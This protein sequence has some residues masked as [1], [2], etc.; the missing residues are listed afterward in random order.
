MIIHI[1]PQNDLKEHFKGDGLDCLCQPRVEKAFGN[2][3]VIHNAWDGRE[4]LED[5]ILEMN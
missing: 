2:Y 3:I 5:L 1:T 4:L